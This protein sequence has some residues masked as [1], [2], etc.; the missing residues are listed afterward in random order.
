MKI[1][2]G[3]QTWILRGKVLTLGQLILK[4]M[5]YSPNLVLVFRDLYYRLQ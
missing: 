3:L 5:A 1:T 4:T 2:T